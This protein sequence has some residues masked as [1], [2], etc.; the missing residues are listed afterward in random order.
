MTN[1][2][3]AEPQA[4]KFSLRMRI[5]FFVGDPLIALGLLA[6]SILAAIAGTLTH[7]P[8]LTPSGVVLAMAAVGLLALLLLMG[9]ETLNGWTREIL[10]KITALQDEELQKLATA[11]RPSGLKLV[12]LFKN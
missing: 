3:Q 8:E 2:V 1:E 10:L 12:S 9:L 11:Q 6:A 5:L 4:P 7:R